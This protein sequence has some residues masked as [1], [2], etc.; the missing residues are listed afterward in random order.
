MGTLSFSYK[1]KQSKDDTFYC[2]KI[3]ITL[4][5]GCSDPMLNLVNFRRWNR[6]FEDAPADCEWPRGEV[7]REGRELG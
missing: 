6:H 7:L 2:F 4:K 1:M 3:T 5:R